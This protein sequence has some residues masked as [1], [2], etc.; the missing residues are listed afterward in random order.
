MKKCEHPYTNNSKGW[1][2]CV[3]CGLCLKRLIAFGTDDYSDRA[4]FK[5]TGLNKGEVIMKTLRKIICSLV[6]QHTALLVTECGIPIKN[7]TIDGPPDCEFRVLFS[8]LRELYFT[9]MDYVAPD[10]MLSEKGRRQSF[11]IRCQ[12][13]SLCSAVLWK[14]SGVV[15]TTN[16]YR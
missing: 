1:K 9:C 15:K 16:D 11:V 7:V 12:N 6:G 10:N 5:N 4:H 13:N 2:I 8:Y 14:K 3:S